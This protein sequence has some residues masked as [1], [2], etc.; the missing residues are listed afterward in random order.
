MN[1]FLELQLKSAIIIAIS[2]LVYLVFLARDSFFQRNRI[3][4][5]T[6]LF[7]PWLMPLLAMPLWLKE[8]LFKPE[9]NTEPL[10]L[11][12]DV[13][14]TEIVA[15]PAPT[16]INWTN[17]GLG[18]YAVVSL[19]FLMRLLWGYY[20]ISRL[21][22]GARVSS[23]KGYQLVLLNDGDVNPFSFFK[24]I[25]MP[26]HLERNKHGRMILEHERTHCAQLHSIDIS[27]AEWLL[28]VQ[29][30]NPF[31]WW[32]R[33]LIA[34]NHEYCVDNAM[35]QKTKEPQAYQY[36]LLNLLQSNR[37]VQLVNNFNQSLTKK[38]IVMMN[39]KHT[40]LIIGWTKNLLLIPLLGLALLA[41]TNPDKTEKKAK[42]VVKIENTTD[43]R[44]A[45]ARS[46]K[47]PLVARDRGVEATVTANFSVNKKGKITDV[48]IGSKPG[49]VKLENVVVVA[50]AGETENAK[51]M[52]VSPDDGNRAL[53]DEVVRVV[54]KLPQIHDPALLGKQLQMDFE[55]KLQSKVSKNDSSRADEWEGRTTK[56]TNSKGEEFA[57]VAT[58]GRIKL[59]GP[60]SNQPALI[61]D[62]KEVSMKEISALDLNEVKAIGHSP[63]GNPLKFLP[64][65]P[66]NGAFIIHTEAF[67]AEKI[68][69]GKAYA[70][71]E[72]SMYIVDGKEVDKEVFG[73]IAPDQIASVNVLKN[74]AA[75]DK[76]G[77]K[78]KDGVV[79]VTT[80][81][82]AESMP[83]FKSTDKVKISSM[84]L[85][86]TADNGETPLFVVD[87]KKQE[88]SEVDEKD[89]ESI[90]VLKEQSAIDLYGE[91][92]KNGVVNINTK[93]G[94]SLDMLKDGGVK[95]NTTKDDPLYIVDGK[96]YSGGG[97]V[98]AKDIESVNVL[99][100]DA[101]IDSY[102]E[103]GRNGVILINTKKGTVEHDDVVVS[104]ETVDI[105][106][107]DADEVVV[108][109][110]GS[111][112]KGNSSTMDNI[113]VRRG[114][115]AETVRIKGMSGDQQ[116]YVILDGEEYT[117]SMEDL[118]SEKI[119]SI[120]VLKDQA[121]ESLYGDKGKNGVIIIESKK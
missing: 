55:F 50:Y 98:N 29:W 67:L 90:T 2:V 105:K 18:F 58:N 114:E 83:F 93:K 62:G 112:R 5:L 23:Y 9:I 65:T 74:S 101:A 107:N 64:S 34:Q 12:F 49:A 32:L 88:K 20:S 15:A 84:K 100:G 63:A 56:L 72:P 117:G 96:K 99:K 31:V 81:G 14:V 33:K 116:P 119:Q 113:L 66:E 82:N 52:E 47:Y 43:L 25:F 21:K 102:G 89:I 115:K 118:D 22:Q 10:A 11:T 40:S 24:T 70:S 75:T 121:A 17:W 44:N 71:S 86:V 85:S 69:A 111:M 73:K 4:L 95:I 27:L 19:F 6:T 106:P 120:S 87:G 108:V 48:A 59:D 77:D 35:V 103:E 97:A 38:R 57:L 13:P 78:A 109:G 80:K 45:I 104:A 61:L 42:E 51:Q 46:I 79:E 68:K 3:W 7:V 39:K 94:K 53:E 37:G 91:E 26:A 16:P 28:V 54:Q 92:G 60:A 110:Y 1:A 30:W 41:F 8:L 76:Y 36:S